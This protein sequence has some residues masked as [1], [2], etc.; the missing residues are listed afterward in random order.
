MIT[1]LQKKARTDFW[2][3]ALDGDKFLELSED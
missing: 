3:S 2:N 1:E